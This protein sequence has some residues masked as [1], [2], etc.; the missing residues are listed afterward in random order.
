MAD[1]DRLRLR[2]IVGQVR[3]AYVK[4]PKAGTIQTRSVETGQFV[5]PGTVLA[6]LVQRD[7]LLLR[8]QVPEAEAGRLTKGMPAAFKVRDSQRAFT[9]T[10]TV[11]SSRRA[12]RSI[13]PAPVRRRRARIVNPSA[14]SARAQ[15]FSAA[16]P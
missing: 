4:A 11:R 5:Q 10:I 16:R 8:F 12:T 6:T 1:R 2:R 15:V 13:S 3:D 14:S 7:P 9:S